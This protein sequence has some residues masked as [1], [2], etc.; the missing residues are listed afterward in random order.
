[1]TNI[2]GM[3]ILIPNVKIQLHIRHAIFLDCSL[4][5]Y[6]QFLSVSLRPQFS[7]HYASPLKLNQYFSVIY[8]YTQTP[9]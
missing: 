5:C 9:F 4:M 1:M 3:L 7:V 6:K 2:L 8:K